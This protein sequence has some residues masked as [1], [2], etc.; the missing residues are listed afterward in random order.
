[1]P[2]TFFSLSAERRESIAIKDG[3]R[4]MYIVITHFTVCVWLRTHLYKII[5]RWVWQMKK[6]NL[7]LSI[8]VIFFYFF[9]SF[10]VC[11]WNE[12]MS[13]NKGSHNIHMHAVKVYGWPIR[14]PPQPS[15]KC[16][17][18][19]LIYDE[20]LLIQGSHAVFFFY[21]HQQNDLCYNKFLIICH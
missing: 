16:E 9:F 20:P 1:M 2:N 11:M 4:Y 7:G 5:I 15:P 19:N 13:A 6:R 3:F 8:Q 17:I 10:I 12:L 18:L 14:R 21:L